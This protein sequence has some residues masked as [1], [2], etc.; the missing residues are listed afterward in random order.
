MPGAIPWG[1]AEIVAKESLGQQPQ[2]RGITSVAARNLAICYGTFL[3]NLHLFFARR[4]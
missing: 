4:I 1:D 3:A 2:L